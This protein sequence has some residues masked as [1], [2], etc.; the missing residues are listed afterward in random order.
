MR[1]RLNCEKKGDAMQKDARELVG[2]TVVYLSTP[3]K[4]GTPR[5]V[6]TE[7][8]SS[9]S[10][11]AG[12]MVIDPATSCCAAGGGSAAGVGNTVW[13]ACMF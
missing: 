10:A 5:A 2:G 1:Q 9:F 12:G 4:Y 7:L 3:A 8:R 11:D 6:R 13:I